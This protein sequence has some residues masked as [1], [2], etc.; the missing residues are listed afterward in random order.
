[1]PTC[2][3][4]AAEPREFAGLLRRFPAARADWPEAAFARQIALPG[5]RLLLVANGPGPRLA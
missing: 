5:R 4:V 2:L 3:L 1:M